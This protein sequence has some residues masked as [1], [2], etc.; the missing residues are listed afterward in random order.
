MRGFGNAIDSIELAGLIILVAVFGI[1]GL[2][3][4]LCGGTPPG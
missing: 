3:F 4:W 1:G 2:V